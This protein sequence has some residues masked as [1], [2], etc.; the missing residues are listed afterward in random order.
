[1]R[2][3]SLRHRCSVFKPV[4]TKNRTGGFDTTWQEAGKVWADIALPTG[5]IAPVAEQLK[6][7][8]TAE[9]R[10]RPRADLLAGYRLVQ[11]GTTYLVEAALPDNTLSMLRLLCSNVANP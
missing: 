6:A 10:V 7:V 11:K 5:R 4:L 8:I 9:I 3:G 1:M 2:A